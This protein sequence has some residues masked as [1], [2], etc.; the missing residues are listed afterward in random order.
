MHNALHWTCPNCRRRTLRHLEWCVC[1]EDRPVIA[2][3]EAPGRSTLKQ[4]A[5]EAMGD[6]KSG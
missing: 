4:I 1:G 3:P 2:E 6:D 5:D